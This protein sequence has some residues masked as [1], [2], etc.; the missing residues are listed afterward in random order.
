MFHAALKGPRLV[1]GPASRR[2][3][4]KK[5]LENGGSERQNK[6]R[7]GTTKPDENAHTSTSEEAPDSKTDSEENKSTEKGIRTRRDAEELKQKLQQLR[8]IQR[9]FD[10]EGP[11]EL[12]MRKTGK[13]NSEEDLA[14]RYRFTPPMTQRQKMFKEEVQRLEKLPDVK[15]VRGAGNQVRII[16]VP[17]EALTKAE[18]DYNSQIAFRVYA[19]SNLFVF[20]WFAGGAVFLYMVWKILSSDPGPPP[21]EPI[22]AKV[23]LDVYQD[24]E[25]IGTIVLGLYT[26]RCPL[27]CENFHRLATG[28]T[29]SG[30]SFRNTDFFHVW[31][32]VGIVAGDYVKNTGSA[33]RPVLPYFPGKRWFPDEIAGKDLPFFRGAL[34]SV[35]SLWSKTDGQNDSLF[36]ISNQGTMKH[37]HSFV[38]FGEVLSGIEV[39]D[40]V[41]KIRLRGGRPVRRIWIK[42]SG[43][44]HHTPAEREMA[45]TPGPVQTRSDRF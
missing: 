15:I 42:Q 1:V 45:N 34:C 27:T 40:T 36:M 19:F 29:A 23:F 4:S 41:S 43:E 6:A 2:Y 13:V 39:V 24:D 12:Q 25:R 28:N 3:C 21:N 18:L 11:M 16:D 44:Y 32:N 5:I 38:I 9:R 8:D 33:G 20:I 35:G 7:V 10:L 14:P 30:V 17:I 22:G 31:K 37:N 26:Q